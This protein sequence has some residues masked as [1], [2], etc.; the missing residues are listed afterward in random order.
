MSE[1]LT[2]LSLNV[3]GVTNFKKDEQFLL[4]VAR[5]MPILYFYKKRTRKGISRYNGETNGLPTL[6]CLMETL[7]LV[8]LLS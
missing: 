7:N 3:R 2:L 4:G 1:T 5:K 6:Y 8:G